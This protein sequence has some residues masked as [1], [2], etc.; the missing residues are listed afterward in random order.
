MTVLDYT[1]NVCGA[2]CRS[3]Q[4]ELGRE[5]ASCGTCRSTVRMREVAYLASVALFGTGLPIPEL[6]VRPE[7]R[8][9][10]LSDWWQYADRLAHHITYTNSWYH[11]EPCLDVTAVPDDHAGRYDL[12][13]ST[14]VFEHVLP[15]VQRAFEGAAR[16]LK[17]DGALVLTVPWRSDGETLEHYEDA[18]GYDVVELDGHQSVDIIDFAGARRRVIDPVFH[19][20]PGSTLEMRVFSLPGILRCL[21]AAGFHSARV[22]RQDVPEF[23]ILHPSDLSL[24]LLARR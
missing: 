17:P 8:G 4:E 20:G 23:G 5:T 14:D 11:Q 13:I 6:P 7:L 22:L 18:V 10:G 24:P 2:R 16:L 12:V 19:G 21:A 3:A 9:I 15:P 1:C